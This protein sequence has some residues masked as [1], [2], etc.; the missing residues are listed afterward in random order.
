MLIHLLFKNEHISQKW[1]IPLITGD[2]GWK[3]PLTELGRFLLFPVFVLTHHCL[4]PGHRDANWYP[5][6]HL[7]SS[8]MTKKVIYKM[9]SFF[10]STQRIDFTGGLLKKPLL[11]PSSSPLR[12]STQWLWVALTSLISLLT[13]ARPFGFQCGE[14]FFFA[15]NDWCFHREGGGLLYFKPWSGRKWKVLTAWK[16][17]FQ[18]HIFQNPNKS[19]RGISY[20]NQLYYLMITEK[21]QKLTTDEALILS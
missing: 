1:T 8:M 21:K 20:Y 7:I 5:S 4:Y 16:H 3:A 10:L 19:T 14:V 12:G 15:L 2:R 18:Q 13:K 6:F 17:F 11:W 9:L